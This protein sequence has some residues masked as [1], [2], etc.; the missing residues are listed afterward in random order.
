VPPPARGIPAANRP[1]IGDN[2][3]YD[4]EPDT[5]PPMLLLCRPLDR[6]EAY[7]LRDILALHGIKAHVF[8]ANMQS[9]IGDVPA[10]VA[11]PQ[12]WLDDDADRERAAEVL[13]THRAERNRRG[14]LFCPRCHEENPATFELCWQCGASL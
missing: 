3:R 13:R 1:R 10:D 5:V 11:L 6:I 2:G 12:V 8:N 9:V 7:L 4:R 14:V